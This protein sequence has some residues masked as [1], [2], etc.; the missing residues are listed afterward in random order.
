MWPAWSSTSPGAHATWEVY[1]SYMWMPV[2]HYVPGAGRLL[3]LT[4]S[5]LF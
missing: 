3:Q 1:G 4:G 2:A 5:W